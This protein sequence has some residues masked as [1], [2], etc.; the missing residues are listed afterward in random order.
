MK[1]LF[2][3]AMVL[4]LPATIVIALLYSF[5]KYLYTLYDERKEL[6]ELDAI[7]AESAARRERNRL[8]NTQRLDNGCPHTFDSGIGFPP[9]VCPKC[10]LEQQK[11]PGDC[12]HVWRRVE[13]PGAATACVKCGKAYGTEI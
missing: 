10:G 13:S 1:Q 8:E 4:V 5:A 2:F 9:G 12:D 3:F 7:Q 11:P 6:K